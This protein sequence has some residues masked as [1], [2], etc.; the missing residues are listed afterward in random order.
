[1]KKKINKLTSIEGKKFSVIAELELEYNV[2]L[3][4]PQYLSARGKT[5]Q[6]LSL[7]KIQNLSATFDL[8]VFIV[9]DPT[10]STQPHRIPSNDRTPLQFVY[11]WDG[12][13]LQVTN[14]S[15][16]AATAQLALISIT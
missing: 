3:N 10:G 1:M 7:L 4:L 16:E 8:E 12:A 2:P 6:N 15:H 13:E 5:N 11:N 9:P 14:A